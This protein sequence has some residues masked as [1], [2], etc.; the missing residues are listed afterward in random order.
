MRRFHNISTHCAL[1]SGRFENPLR[2]LIH[3]VLTDL[4][5]EGQGDEFTNLPLSEKMK[6]W[7]KRGFG[8]NPGGEDWK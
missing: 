3:S 1:V 8:T 5:E 6:L 7:D 4:A 2:V